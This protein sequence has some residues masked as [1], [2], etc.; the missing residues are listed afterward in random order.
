MCTAISLLKAY[1]VKPK[2]TANDEAITV[3]HNNNSSKIEIYIFVMFHSL[4]KI[5]FC[6]DLLFNFD[7]SY[8]NTKFRIVLHFFTKITINPSFCNIEIY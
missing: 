5:N 1:P 7:N 6:F 8:Y 3:F 4:F 2:V